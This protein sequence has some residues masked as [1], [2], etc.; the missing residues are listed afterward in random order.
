M[1]PFKSRAYGGE[2]NKSNSWLSNRMT[3]SENGQSHEEKSQV[4]NVLVWRSILLV[5]H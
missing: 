1:K 3:D 2:S 5:P 4:L